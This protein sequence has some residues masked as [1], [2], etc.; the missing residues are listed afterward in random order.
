MTARPEKWRES[1]IEAPNRS[2]GRRD[3]A[4]AM[5]DLERWTRDDLL[6]HPA[7]LHR[8][9]PDAFTGPEPVRETEGLDQYLDE[10]LRGYACGT[11]IG[12]REVHLAEAVL[13]DRLPDFDGVE[14]M[15][16]VAA[17]YAIFESSA[18]GR[19]VRMSAV[20]SGDS[21]AYQADIDAAL[22]IS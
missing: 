18:A 19:A 9:K 1:A 13:H 14:G 11:G 16:D 8:R 6:R 7:V 15:K 12:V 20:E 17:I 3:T 22:G 10:Y 5:A 2:F 4:E 21:Y